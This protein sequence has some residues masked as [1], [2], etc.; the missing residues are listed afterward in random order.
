M[1]FL[2]SALV[3][4]AGNINEQTAGMV[5]QSQLAQMGK[6][7]EYSIHRIIPVPDHTRSTLFYMIELAPTGYLETIS[8]V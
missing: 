4:F 5:A 2:F 6:S 3:L 1:L 7:D 8:P